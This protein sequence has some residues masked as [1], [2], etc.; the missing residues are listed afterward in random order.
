MRKYRLRLGIYICILVGIIS[1]LSLSCFSY[2]QEIYAN[3]KMKNDL[4]NKY[5]N[6][7]ESEEE[8]EGQVIKLQDPEYVA[9]YAREKFYYSKDGELIIKLPEE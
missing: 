1:I 8:L 5:A 2:W 9:K 7:V 6:L 3:K 4:E